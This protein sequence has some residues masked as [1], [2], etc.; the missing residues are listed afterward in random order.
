MRALQIVGIGLRVLAI[1]LFIG[2]LRG[3]A[4][5]VSL[6][7]KNPSLESLIMIG[8]VVLISVLISVWVW[9][10]PLT[11]A[12]KLVPCIPE[13]EEDKPITQHEFQAIGFS[14]IG[15]WVLTQS[16]P[17]IFSWGFYVYAIMHSETAVEY[18]MEDFAGIVVT[19]V[20]LVLGIFLLLGSKG[21]S[22]VIHKFRY[23]GSGY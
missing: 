15:L 8:V 19:G 11:I 2:T 16:I 13:S 23:A 12:S 18:S 5:F 4:P 6:Y 22:G 7:T 17:D 1:L 3:M 21:L 9:F 14:L 10:F 20:E